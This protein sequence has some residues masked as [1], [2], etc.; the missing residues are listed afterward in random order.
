MVAFESLSLF[1][2]EA[3]F[4][5]TAP[6]RRFDGDG[7]LDVVGHRTLFTDREVSCLPQFFN[8]RL[9]SFLRGAF[10]QIVSQMAH[11]GGFAFGSVG[12]IFLQALQRLDKR[13]S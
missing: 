1:F 13:I 7:W 2:K 9:R 6:P 10:A 5:I 8:D 12:R 3:V 4:S 11:E